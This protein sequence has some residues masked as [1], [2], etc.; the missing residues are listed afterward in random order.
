MKVAQQPTP[1][2]ALLHLQRPPLNNTE[3]LYTTHLCT[4]I[5][6]CLLTCTQNDTRMRFAM[7]SFARLPKSLRDFHDSRILCCSLS[8]C[9]AFGW[10]SA[11]FGGGDMHAHRIGRG[12]VP[13]QAENRNASTP[14]GRTPFSQPLTVDWRML[15][16]RREVQSTTVLHC[17]I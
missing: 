1:P 13:P 12:T 7:L 2:S 6:F 9:W 8:R 3:K 5:Y 16:P 11:F 17:K 4:F 10:L 14:F 15:G